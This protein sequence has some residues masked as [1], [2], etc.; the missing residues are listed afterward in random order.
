MKRII[1]LSLLFCLLVLTSCAIIEDSNIKESKDESFE[2]GVGSV[3]ESSGIFSENSGT[4]SEALGETS[5]EHVDAFEPY[6]TKISRADFPIYK[7]VGYE[8]GF[9]SYVKKASAYTI[10]EEAEDDFGNLWGRL[11]SG[12]GWIDLTRLEKEEARGPVL[13]LLTLTDQVLNNGNFLHCPAS[14]E[15]FATQ[16]LLK[17]NV[18]LVRIEFYPTYIGDDNSLFE[19]PTTYTQLN[20]RANTFLLV[21]VSFPGDLSEYGI[22]AIDKDGFVHRYSIY[23]NLSGEGDDYMMYSYAPQV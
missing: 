23:S 21:D 6:V 10:I 9:A 11:K 5:S 17:A 2:S 1:A 8:T 16:I 14:T 15:E 18:E 13:T 7:G 20:C 4:T 12:A 3:I 19:E 22:R